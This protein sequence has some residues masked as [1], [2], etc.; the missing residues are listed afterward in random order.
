MS[1][2]E[3]FIE[4]ANAIGCRVLQGC[5]D[6][7]LTS[8]SQLEQTAFCFIDTHMIHVLWNSLWTC[9]KLDCQ[10]DCIRCVP[11]STC[12][13]H[14]CEIKSTREESPG[15]MKKYVII[16]FVTH[17]NI[18]TNLSCLFPN[19]QILYFIHYSQGAKWLITII[20]IY[21]CNNSTSNYWK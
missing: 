8:L 21:L 14:K 18:A 15:D 17:V 1:T 10:K 11:R 16:Q 7:R 20:F 12:I 13:S 2:N 6:I 5:V 9:Q 19:F 3:L 4:Y